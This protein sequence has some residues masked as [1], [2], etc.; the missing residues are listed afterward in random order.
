M[1]IKIE[2]GRTHQIRVHAAALG[3][4][5]AGDDKYGDKQ[6]N[7][8]MKRLGLARLFLHAGSITFYEPDFSA[9]LVAVGVGLDMELKKILQKI[10][11]KVK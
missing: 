5:I 7:Q 11:M 10:G 2:T 3:F 6:F 8:E 4:P 1:L 9:F